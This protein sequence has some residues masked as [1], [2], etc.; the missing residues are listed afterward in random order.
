LNLRSSG[1]GKRAQPGSS[2]PKGKQGIKVADSK[3]AEGGVPTPKH[4]KIRYKD[5]V[6]LLF[7]N[8]DFFIENVLA[9]AAV[10]VFDLV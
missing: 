7:F 4:R 6:L 5:F 10:S 2:V 3:G 9:F 8:L 1:Q